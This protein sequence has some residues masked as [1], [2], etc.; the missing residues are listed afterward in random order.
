MATVYL[1]TCT[2]RAGPMGRVPLY[3]EDWYPHTSVGTSALSYIFQVRSFGRTSKHC[4]GV[5]GRCHETTF[6]MSLEL[7]GCNCLVVAGALCT[8][9]LI[10]F[11]PEQATF[12]TPPAPFSGLPSPIWHSVDQQSC[13]YRAPAFPR[14]RIEGWMPILSFC[15]S[16]WNATSCATINGTRNLISLH[17]PETASP[18]SPQRRKTTF[19]ATGR[20][21]LRPNW[22]C[23][24]FSSTYS[25]LL[26]C[27]CQCRHV[28][29]RKS[30]MRHHVE[31][32]NCSSIL[33]KLTHLCNRQSV[34]EERRGRGMEKKLE[35]L[36]SHRVPLVQRVFENDWSEK[37]LR[38]HVKALPHSDKK[39]RHGKPVQEGW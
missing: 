14:P 26:R 4:M 29:S 16:T 11:A 2:C 39:S 35:L 17:H 32:L 12:Y 33:D 30:G 25:P 28:N 10:V 15:I 23:G 8:T 18:Q 20:P 13:L 3:T 34:R 7:K 9:N 36:P 19:R 6:W 5:P 38:Y 21:H 24:V 37:V 1:N 27:C 22:V 31:A